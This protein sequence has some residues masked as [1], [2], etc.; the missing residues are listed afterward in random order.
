M[1]KCVETT[2]DWPNNNKFA[3]VNDRINSRRPVDIPNAF[4]IDKLL[5]KNTN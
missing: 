4:K 2:K 3:W 5:S 1:Q